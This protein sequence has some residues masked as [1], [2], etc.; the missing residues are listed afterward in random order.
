[1]SDQTSLPYPGIFNLNIN[2]RSTDAQH[3]P[4]TGARLESVGVPAPNPYYSIRHPDHLPRFFCGGMTQAPFLCMSVSDVQP[5]DHMGVAAHTD[6]AQY[7]HTFYNPI[8]PAIQTN[9]N[10]AS[11]NQP[12][13]AA[14]PKPVREKKPLSVI[15][16][17]T[18]S[19]VNLEEASRIPS[20][21][22]KKEPLIVQPKADES[23]PISQTKEESEKPVCTEY[24]DEGISSVETVSQE[25]APPKESVG[26]DDLCNEVLEHVKSLDEHLSQ[27]DETEWEGAKEEEA[28][29]ET[30]DRQRYP[31][32]FILSCKASGVVLSLDNYRDIMNSFANIKRTRNQSNYMH[33]GRVI[34]IPTTITIKRVEGAFVPSKLVNHGANSV[35]DSSKDVA[36]E[37][38]MILNRVSASNLEVTISDIEK[39]NITT[40]EDLSLLAR[41]IFQKV[42]RQSKYCKVFAS[43]CKNLKGLEVQGS[44]RFPVLILQ[45]TQELFNKPLDVL[46]SE[47]NATIDAKIAA[48]KDE[49]IKR[50]LEDDRETNIQKT[51]DSYYGN[52][53]FIAELY[54]V[55]CIPIKTMTECLKKLKDSSAPEALT[56]LIILLNICGSNL[57][58]N[59]KSVLDQCFKRL[60]Q[61]KDSKNIETHQI[62]KVHELVELR[63]RDWKSANITQPQPQI[64]TSRRNIDDKL[65]RNFIQLDTKRKSVQSVNPLTP[66]SLAVT[67]QSYDSRKLGPTVANWSQGSGLLRPSEDN[68]SKRNQQSVHSRESSPRVPVGPQ[69]AWARP[70]PLGQK[71]KEN[72]YESMLEETKGPARSIVDTVS[73]S[74]DDCHCSIV[75]CEPEKRSALLHNVFEI[76]MDCNSKKR[77]EVGRFCVDMLHKGI[78]T[79]NN[80]I[81]SC[82]NF[83]KLCDSD[84]ISDYPQGWLYV[85][86]ILHHLI[87]GE[88]DYMTTLLRSVESIRSDDRAAELVAD[89]IKLSKA[90]TSVEQL[91]KKLQACGFMWDKLG[92]TGSKTWDFAYQR[93][94]EFT[95]IGVHSFESGKLNELNELTTNPSSP[96][97]IS[98]YFNTLSQYNLSKW[99]MQSIIPILLKSPDQSKTKIDSFVMSLGILVDHK[100]DRELH[101]LSGFQ[102]PSSNQVL[103]GSWLTSLVEKK[104]ISADALSQWKKSD[105]DGSVAKILSGI[106]ELRNL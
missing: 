66:S 64:D 1:M 42:I 72:D 62:F 73:M 37:L 68:H 47:L 55:G 8:I 76:L 25:D 34:Q 70:L 79:E 97:K 51:T 18:N 31:R 39:L 61:V 12:L 78:L 15:D 88:S 83:F 58:K 59:S 6:C 10:Q 69:G 16:P 100:P 93:S 41:T 85:A 50:M 14:L 80:I 95:I 86:E 22:R 33:K 87:R 7:Q 44:E 53:T 89:C 28:K 63:S 4:Q 19:E 104:V 9:P 26:S 82:E 71:V 96:D 105:N 90:S 27:E 17:K 74:S 67:P 106:P 99:F 94:I 46:I 20:E 56:S 57:E 54:L 91:V 84:W 35:T 60:E 23:P 36:R 43:L 38:N 5:H 29:E 49:S 48:A 65:K 98:S 40:P 77:N 3:M 24:K 11:G 52:M 32:D 103:V 13:N 81:T 101:I 30:M 45:Q 75:K 21:S 92:V 102:D 2:N